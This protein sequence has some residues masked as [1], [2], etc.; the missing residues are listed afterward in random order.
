MA[1][2]QRRVSVVLADDHDLV[3]DGVRMLLASYPFVK[4]I[5]EAGNG[6]EALAVIRKSEPDIALVD[7]SMPKR[8][9]FGVL[10][11]VQ[12]LK[13]KTRVVL[14]SMYDEPE[15]ALRAHRLGA[16]A[17]LPKSASGD[18]LAE[19]LRRVSEGGG[20]FRTLSRTS[21]EGIALPPEG[22]P[23][24]SD[25]EREILELVVNG[26]SSREVGERLGIS[27]RTA[28]VHRFN[29]MRKLNVSNTAEL[30]KYAL[31]HRLAGVSDISWQK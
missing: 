25:R 27:V 8:D 4:V 24:L 28:E 13:L 16:S 26:L 20:W 3:R 29:I 21:E 22:S 5:G 12:R 30:V 23:A 15:Y 10:A 19:T 1:A 9:G 31:L 7:V 17:Y 2:S 18:E 14:L 11:E 6:E